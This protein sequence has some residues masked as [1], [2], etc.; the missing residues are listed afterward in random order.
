MAFTDN[1]GNPKGLLGRMML[2]SMDREHLPMAEWGLEQLAIPPAADIIDLGC[3]GGYNIKRMLHRCDSGTVV[4]FDIS[5]ESVRKAK[6]VN[7]D[8]LGKRVNI[9]RGSVSQIPFSDKSFDLATAFE[10]VFFWPNAAEDIKEVFRVVRPGGQFAVINN[11]GDP[12]ID[13][14][15]KVPC[16]TRYTSEQIAAFMEAA[17]FDT[18]NISKNGNL[19]CVIGR[20]DSGSSRNVNQDEA[21]NFTQGSANGEK[22]AEGTPSIQYKMVSGLFKLIG[23]NKMLDKQGKDF[24]KLLVDSARK[25]KKPL[26]IPYNK[27]ENKFQIQLRVMDGMTCYIV[28]SKGKTPD[29][30]VLYLFGGGYILPPDPGD[31]ILCGQ[32]AE[33]CNAEVWFPLYPMAPEHKLVETLDS[34][35][36][37]YREMLKTYSSEDIRFFG[38]SSGGGQA[39]SLCVYIRQKHSD[40]PLPGKLVLQSPG[41][42]VPPS[43]KQKAEMEKL[44]MD[45]VMIPPRFFDNIAP[46]LACEKEAY[47]LSPILSDLT[48]FPPIDIFYGTKEVMIAYLPDMEEACVKYSVPLHVHIGEGMMHCWGAMEFVPEAKA[49]RQEYF[50]AL[51]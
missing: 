4:G 50:Q 29:K 16:M 17:G 18:V 1:F 27:L 36:K 10:T 37:V 42:Q 9:V 6:K 33:N 23:V 40:V 35:L 41:L 14:E 2:V 13:W 30:A 3:G 12:N 46:V 47:L 34:T 48:G 24:E 19:F 5:E 49:V 32:F 22:V 25:Q 21:S 7:K 8:E 20:K 31:L 38:T 15:K 45:D 39:M 11:Y 43:E 51:R 26:K 44:K 28:K